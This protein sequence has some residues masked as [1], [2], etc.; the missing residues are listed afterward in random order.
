MSI[1]ARPHYSD[2]NKQAYVLLCQQYNAAVENCQDNPVTF[3]ALSVRLHI[4]MGEVPQRM[5]RPCFVRS[6]GVSTDTK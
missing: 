6:C 3:V 2:Q 4:M 5:R 1:G